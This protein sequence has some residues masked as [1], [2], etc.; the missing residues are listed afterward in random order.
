MKKE[1]IKK[2]LSTFS[3]LLEMMHEASALKAKGESEIMVNRCVA[4]LRK[5]ALNHAESTVKLTKSQ[6]KETE[7]QPVTYLNMEVK[8]LAAPKVYYQNDVI[9]L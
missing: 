3:N 4:E 8:N 5:E 1:E 9:T 2:H 6:F 7:I